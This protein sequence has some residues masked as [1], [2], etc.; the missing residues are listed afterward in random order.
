MWTLLRHLLINIDNTLQ[1]KKHYKSLSIFV[2]NR[3]SDFIN[4]INGFYILKVHKR[5]SINNP[6]FNLIKFRW[7]N[8]I[9]VTN[10]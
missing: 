4:I 8:D 1:V 5:Y 7:N 2:P 3:H 6:Y 10:V 9:S